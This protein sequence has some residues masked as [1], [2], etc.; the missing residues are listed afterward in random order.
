MKNK[1]ILILITLLFSSNL[2]S[3][4]WF[5]PSPPKIVMHE[6]LDIKEN[7]VVSFPIIF[8]ERSNYDLNLSLKPRLDFH[9]EEGKKI[10]W[11]TPFTF[12]VIIESNNKVLFQKTFEETLDHSLG[13]GW[14][15][16]V[17]GD[18]PINTHAELKIRF[19]KV[20]NTFSFIYKDGSIIVKKLPYIMFLN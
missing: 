5:S 9:S 2:V 8:N 7:S 3:A 16:K 6:T 12:H 11:G 10:N 20:D 13:Y 15:L 17:P 4:G 18:L 1:I 19:E 14:R